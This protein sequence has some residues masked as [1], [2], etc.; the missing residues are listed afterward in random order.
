MH[1]LWLTE[2]YPPNRG[3]MAQSCDRIVANLRRAGVHVHVLHFCSRSAA[4]QR[5]TCENGSYLPATLHESLEHTLNLAWLY[6][7]QEVDSHAAPPYT[8]LVAFGGNVPILAAPLWAKY[9]RLPLV[10][11]L[12]GNDWDAA[13]YSPQRRSALF[14]AL[15][16]AAHVAAVSSDKAEW[17]RRLFPSLPTTFTPNGI[18]LQGWQLL[19]SDQRRAQS[20]RKEHAENRLVVG[21]F[22]QLKAKKGTLFFLQTLARLSE[23][24]RERL[25][26]L[27]VGELEEAGVSDQL[28]ACGVRH[29]LLPFLDRY[30]LMG[31][32]AACDAVA[33]PSFYDGMPNVLLEAGALG[34]PFVASAVAG[35][36]DVLEDGKDAFLFAAND[37]QALL[38]ALRRLLAADSS[39]LQTMGQHLRQKIQTQYT[40]SA[41][42]ARYV[43]LFEA[44]KLL[45]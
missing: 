38:Q 10:V 13:L 37:A 43:A 5:Q 17:L 36:R 18:E 8:H 12:R 2:N 35:M 32:Y 26:L 11:L 40:E 21:L 6:L 9:L 29:T 44:T 20:W 16:N 22:G 1:L 41:E 15:E 34:L 14:Y 45:D 33:I 25:H 42:V 31:Y 24:E 3:G 30:E 27:V 28:A 23:A 39:Q 7:L 4:L 19:P